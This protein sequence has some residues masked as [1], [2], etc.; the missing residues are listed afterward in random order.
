MKPAGRARG[1]ND[2]DIEGGQIGSSWS[3]AGPIGNTSKSRMS[4]RKSE[5]RSGEGPTLDRSA[6][7]PDVAALIGKAPTDTSRLRL[8]ITNEYQTIVASSGDG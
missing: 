1:R 7:H 3:S 5:R 4:R 8:A 2:M 6:V